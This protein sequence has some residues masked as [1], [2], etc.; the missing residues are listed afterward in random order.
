MFAALPP[1]SAEAEQRN[2]LILEE[3]EILRSGEVLRF[4]QGYE[5]LLRGF[6]TDAVMVEFYNNYRSPLFVGSTVLREGE[7]VR[8]YRIIDGENILILT[9]TLDHLYISSTQIIARFTYIY[10][11]E[12]ENTL[13]PEWVWALTTTVLEDPTIPYADDPI[14]TEYPEQDG[15]YPLYIILIV[16]LAAAATIA[17]NFIFRKRVE[18]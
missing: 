12:D 8:C 13:Y 5:V 7:T 4:A 18:K 17:A 15:V 14:R 16:G 2:I 9:M 11:F 6:G 3:Y 1:A 10:Q